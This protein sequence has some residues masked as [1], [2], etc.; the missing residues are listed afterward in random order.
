MATYYVKSS[1]NNASAGTSVGT[2]WQTLSKV[3]GFTF[4]SGDK[5]MFQS[6]DTFTGM[7]YGSGYANVTFC[8]YDVATGLEASNGTRATLQSTTPDTVFGSPGGVASVTIRNLELKTNQAVSGAGQATIIAPDSA[9]SSASWTVTYCLIHQCGGSGIRIPGNAGS[10][11]WTISYN[12]IYDCGDNGI[13]VNASNGGSHIVEYNTIYNTGAFNSSQGRHGIYANG[14][15]TIVRYNT[16]HDNV[17]GQAISLRKAGQ[18]AHG[19]YIYSTNYAIGLFA[20]GDTTAG[21]I[22]VFSN[23]INGA[24]GYGIYVGDGSSTYFDTT[25]AS[26]TLAMGAGAIGIDC[27]DI[28]HASATIKN[29][30][31]SGGATAFY[32]KNASL[33]GGE[34][35]TEN[36][37]CFYNQTSSTPFR[38]SGSSYNFTN[39]KATSSQGANSTTSN[40]IL[41]AAPTYTPTT[42]GSA[43]DTGTTTVTGLTYSTTSGDVIY[44]TPAPDMGATETPNPP[45]T[46]TTS[47]SKT[48][49]FTATASATFVPY[50]P[51]DGTPIELTPKTSSGLTLT[52]KY[53][54]E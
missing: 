14:P 27:Q 6:G 43:I 28:L 35:I 1:G 39:Y 5:V 22:L 3:S 15:S 20:N 17:N 8:S 18:K 50:V 52:P 23:I 32:G 49:T 34:S 30:I 24:T 25:I 38:W 48:F 53:A 31:V 13:L 47:L 29:N 45:S 19:N 41:G 9:S 40:P 26:N 42:G 51:P 11:G 46:S 16:F 36:Y 2:A 4:T 12:S 21:T 7:I 10:T 33:D 37:N 54:D 44:N